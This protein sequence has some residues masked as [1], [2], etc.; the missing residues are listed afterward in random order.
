VR[1]V[2]AEARGPGVPDDAEPRVEALVAELRQRGHEVE[3]VTLPFHGATSTALAEASAWRL[4]D[5]S[6]AGGRAI[7][8]LIAMGF[9]A[10]FARHPHKVAWLVPQ[11]EVP[12]G[13]RELDARMRAECVR[14]ITAPVYHP[15]LVEQLLG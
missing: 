13:L 4:L 1:I 9:P 3:A 8:L 7:D 15:Q 6:T 11:Q 10:H 14:V 2:V 5:L 12:A